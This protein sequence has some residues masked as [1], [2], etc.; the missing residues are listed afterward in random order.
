L[1]IFA[2]ARPRW[3]YEWRE[4][5]SGGTDIVIALD[6]STSML[7]TDIS[8]NRLERAKREIIDLL[9]ILKGDRI[10]IVAFAGVAFVYTPLTIDYRLADMFINQL[11]LK[12]MPVQGTA[13]GEALNQS[14]DALEKASSADTQG[15]T[16]ILITDGEDQNGDALESAKKAKEKGIKIFAVGIGSD[17]G[18]PIPMPDGGFKKDKEGNIVVSKLGEQ[19]LQAITAETGGSYVR[20][21]SGNL[22]LD[23]IYKQI[24]SGKEGE[25]DTSRQKIWYERFQIFLAIAL[26]LLIFEFFFQSSRTRSARQW[27]KNLAVL[28]FVILPIFDGNRDAQ[29]SDTREGVKAYEQ[30]DYKAAADKFLRAEIKEPDQPIHAYN[31]GVSQ[32]YNMQYKEA[33]EAFAKSAQAQDKTLAAKSYY[34]LGN[35]NVSQGDFK[36]AV[37]AYE[38]ALQLNPQDKDAKENLEWAKKKL[39]EQKQQKEDD[40]KEDKKDQKQDDKDK[41]EESKADK[42]QK[43]DP[44]KDQ[45]GKDDSEQ[46][47]DEKK[48]G[49]SD[50]KDSDEKKPESAKPEEA[51]SEGHGKELTQEQAEKLLRMIEDQEQVYGMP[52]RYAKPSKTPERDW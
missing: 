21:T 24:K 35:T 34:N 5:H 13:I 4:V 28:F 20:S 6:L 18:A 2:L 11:S 9:K 3:D 36:E 22:D 30:K 10:G 45:E 40:K 47:K 52:P 1:L 27:W 8:P 37:K 16:I 26:A 29:A 44:N 31:R 7:A 15:K 51:K 25:G 38:Q 50:K 48:E 43:K 12:L 42:S 39:E 17:A 46:K 33:A 19:T 23:V 49:G 14:I 41:K 32:F